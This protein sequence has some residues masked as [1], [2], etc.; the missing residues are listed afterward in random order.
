MEAGLAAA[1]SLEEDEFDAKPFLA[2]VIPPLLN[3]GGGKCP[4]VS[5]LITGLT[6]AYRSSLHSR[7]GFRFRQRVFLPASL[8][9]VRTISPSGC[10]RIGKSFG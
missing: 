6:S 9:S 2:D 1:G 10:S 7:A 3:L 4:Q 5:S 8:H